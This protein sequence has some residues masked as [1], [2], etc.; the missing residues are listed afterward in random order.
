MICDQSAA[1]VK[2]WRRRRL[3]VETDEG[4]SDGDDRLGKATVVKSSAVGRLVDRL[5]I[6][7][8]SR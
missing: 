8:P 2:G 6:E 7:R 4:D 5:L 3:T 1:T